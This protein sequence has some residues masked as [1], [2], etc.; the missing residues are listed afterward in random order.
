MALV[1]GAASGCILLTG[2]TEGY[3]LP[4]GGVVGLACMGSA[5]CDAGVCCYSLMG[6]T[7]SSQC[8]AS[9]TRPFEQACSIAEDCGD[10]G[11]CIA[12]SCPLPSGVSVPV[13]TC[14]PIPVCA[15]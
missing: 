7:P 15:Q 8:Q 3:S 5:E 12:Q 1:L 4:E 2:G 11:I 13:T 10:G 6:T 14:G 9:C